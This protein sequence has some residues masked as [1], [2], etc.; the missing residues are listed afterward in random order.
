MVSLFDNNKQYYSFD[1]SPNDALKLD[2]SF[3]LYFMVIILAAAAAG[4]LIMTDINE[5]KYNILPIVS[6]QLFTVAVKIFV[7]EIYNKYFFSRLD[8]TKACQK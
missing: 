8:Y 1:F 3:Y 6:Y 4:A 7:S 5:L 2:F